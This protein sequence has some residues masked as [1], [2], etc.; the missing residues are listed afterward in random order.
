VT[1]TMTITSIVYY[2]VATRTWKWPAWKA[3]LP[4]LLFLAFDLTYFSSTLL[5][6]LDGGWFPILVATGIFAM[7][8][9]WKV[10]RGELARR[11]AE[12]TMPLTMFLEDIE[13]RK[14]HRVAGTAVFMFSNPDGV[15]PVL[16]HHLKHNQVLHS[17]VV[18][19]SV[20]SMDQPQVPEP[21]RIKLEDMGHGFYRVR[22]FYGFM[23]T[24][25]VPDVLQ[26]CRKLGLK[27]AATSTSYYLGRETLLTSGSGRMWRWRKGL[28]AFLS[29]NAR[30]ATYYF[31]IPPGR[32]VELGMQIDL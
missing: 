10:G 31:G 16:L 13:R 12:S 3:G 19:L 26:K 17:Q 30:P 23:E 32:V 22:A 21:E 5:K 24:P 28:F 27:S 20:N 6:F 7:M 8:T 15:P 9:T 1:G 2:V 11:V 29:R 18:L 4:V 14:P 25:N